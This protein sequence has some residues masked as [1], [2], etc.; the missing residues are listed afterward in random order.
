MPELCLKDGAILHYKDLGRGRPILLVHGFGMTGESF[1]PQMELAKIGRIIIPDLRGCGKS[2]L[3]SKPL[4]IVTL[5][6]D[7]LELIEQLGLKDVIW[8]GWSMG[9]IILW[10]AL[11]LHDL[12]AIS[13][14]I[15]I[16]M[17]AKVA[18]EKDWQFGIKG[19]LSETTASGAARANKVLGQMRDNWSAA[20]PRMVARIPASGNAKISSTKAIEDRLTEIALQNDGANAASLW[21]GLLDCDV[22]GKI[23]D[24]DIDTTIIQGAKSQLYSPK[25]C[26]YMAKSL[27]NA[28]LVC[29]ENSGHAPHLEEAQRFNSIVAENITQPNSVEGFASKISI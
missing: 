7:L 3:G 26:A 18:N 8:I 11:G 9:A 17:T 29:F 16:D 14:M 12:K 24:F 6:D 28:E 22:R 20:A 15:A 5:G 1:W 21:R 23:E 10:N 19:L 2:S 27:P 25:V 4:N 13:K